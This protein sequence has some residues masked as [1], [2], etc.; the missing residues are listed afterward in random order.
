M[1]KHVLTHTSHRWKI[2]RFTL[3][4]KRLPQKA[5]DQR[6]NPRHRKAT[7]KHRFSRQVPKL[8][9]HGF[10]MG[11]TQHVYLENSNGQTFSSN[12]IAS[13]CS[14]FSSKTHQLEMFP[15]TLQSCAMVK[16]LWPEHCHSRKAAKKAPEPSSRTCKDMGISTTL[17]RTHVY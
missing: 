11:F 5:R 15:A 8:Q 9:E 3:T 6:Q 1:N 12:E 10:S 13:T 17:C 4:S 7:P 2:L 14:V 16:R